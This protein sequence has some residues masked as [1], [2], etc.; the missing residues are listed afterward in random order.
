MTVLIV[1]EGAANPARLI[2]V[3]IVKILVAPKL[4]GGVKV[5]VV[6]I[7]GV[8]VYAVPVSAVFCEGVVWSQVSASA[9]PPSGSCLKIAII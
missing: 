1:K 3:M 2:A 5:L 7:H 4:K 6:F 9:K 8:F